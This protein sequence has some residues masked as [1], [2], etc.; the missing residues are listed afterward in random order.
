M[1]KTRLNIAILAAMSLFLGSCGP[2]V[3]TTPVN[4]YEKGVFLMNEGAFSGGSGTVTHYNP[5]SSKVRQ[6]IFETENARPLGNVGQSMAVIGENTYLVANG[7]NKIEIVDAKFKSV[8]VINAAQIAQPRYILGINASTAY[9]SQWGSDGIS[10]KVLVVDLATKQVTKSI[11]T[12]SGSEQMVR[13][14]NLVFVVNAGG[15]G[16]DSTVAVIDVTT[17]SLTQKIVVGKQPN[18][19]LVD[20]AGTTIWVLC[21]GTQDFM[22]PANDTKGSIWRINAATAAVIDHQ[23]M[24]TNT[25]HPAKM[26]LGN[27]FSAVYFL[28]N[29]YGGEVF[30]CTQNPLQI[31]TSPVVPGSFLVIGIDPVRN[32]Q[33]NLYAA[34]G[35]FTSNGTAYK[36]TITSA[37]AA[38]KTDSFA[39]GLIPTYFL[40]K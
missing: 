5:D 11:E 3:P 37:S 14:G 9:V 38:T 1:N 28:S 16:V 21:G 10:G 26:V 32:N 27:E 17:N 40:F 15:F 34:K 6:N 22:N 12:G 30:S 24:P 13:V 20:K 18:S 29:Y 4:V 39:V 23:D 2:E 31:S 25:F 33:R 7:A 8:G 35:N 36:Y 19:I